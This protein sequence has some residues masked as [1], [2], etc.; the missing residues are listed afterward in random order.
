MG[1]IWDSGLHCPSAHVNILMKNIILQCWLGKPNEVAQLSSANI[2][3]YA[4]RI[5]AEYEFVRG[6]CFWP[7]MRLNA[8]CQKLHMLD[9]R[10]DDYDFVA[11]ID[12]DIFARKGAEEN[13]FTDTDG[14]GMRSSYLST[15]FKMRSVRH[16]ELVN[17]E[18][19]VWQGGVYRL[20]RELRQTLREHITELDLYKLCR[21]RYQGVDE[22]VM[23]RLAALADVKPGFLSTKWNCFDDDEGVGDAVLI[24]LR[25][26]PWY[27]DPLAPKIERYH[28]LVKRGLI[29]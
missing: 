20:S 11:M 23:H 13:I 21:F 6:R 24:H 14:V 4:S 16:P 25:D 9:E 8:F 22:A 15:R 17:P 18:Y 12:C 27:E 5:D 3:Q 19:P 29:E 2:S 28:D 1:W 26:A 7:Q 10:F